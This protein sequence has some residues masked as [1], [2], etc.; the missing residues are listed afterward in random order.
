M[1]MNVKLH[2]KLSKEQQEEREL[3]NKEH[4]LSEVPKILLMKTIGI[5]NTWD[6]L[7]LYPKVDIKSYFYCGEDKM[8]YR[9]IKWVS[10]NKTTTE[11]AYVYKG[12][13]GK[14]TI[15]KKS[16]EFKIDNITHYPM[17]FAYDN[18]KNILIAILLEATEKTT[19]NITI[20]N[21]ESNIL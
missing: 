2:Y 17:S 11:N 8:E 19:S 13:K 16:N 20:K 5:D 6:L 18:E 1:G 7:R 3:F 14:I 9:I 21:A 4:G 15:D 10:V 12:E